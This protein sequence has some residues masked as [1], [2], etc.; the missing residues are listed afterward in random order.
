MDF[1]TKRRLRKKAKLCY[2]LAYV[3]IGMFF[4]TLALIT[5]LSDA[6][7][8]PLA[9]YVNVFVILTPV[10][11]FIFSSMVS[12]ALAQGYKQTLLSYMTSIRQYRARRFF[13]QILFQI[14]VL[15]NVQAGVDIY[16][17][18]HFNYEPYLD[19]YLYAVMI[20]ECRHSG[21][22]SLANIATKK[23]NKLKDTFSPNKIEF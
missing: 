1:K 5:V 15:G 11:L 3:S 18:H 13:H 16:K 8:K 7:P 2:I 17:S 19:D 4:L 20:T 12:F 14:Q 21:I 9:N 22:T 6:F 23:F 10:L